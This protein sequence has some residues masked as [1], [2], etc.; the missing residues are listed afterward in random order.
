MS[1]YWFKVVTRPGEGLGFRMAGAAVEEVEEGEVGG[2]LQGPAG[3]PRAVGSWPWRRS[4][5]S[6]CPS[7]SCRRSVARGSRSCCPSRFP[8]RWEE[9]GRGEEYVATLI[10]RAIGYH[11]KIQ[12]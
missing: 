2:A 11:V 9:A 1:R 7:R 4:C 12:R 5:S 3:R 6:G 8:R 10:R